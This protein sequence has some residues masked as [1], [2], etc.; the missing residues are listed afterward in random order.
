M[1]VNEASALNALTAE[2][3]S[4]SRSKGEEGRGLC[5]CVWQ[6]AHILLPDNPEGASLALDLESRLAGR[7]SNRTSKAPES[8]SECSAAC[9][10]L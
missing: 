3:I 8:D 2:R 5:H 1:C 4:M 9:R 7:T 10:V 6:V